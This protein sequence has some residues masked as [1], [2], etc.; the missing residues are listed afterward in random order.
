MAFRSIQFGALALATAVLTLLGQPAAMM[1]AASAIPIGLVADLSGS[2]SVYG[3]SIRNGAHLAADLLNKAGGINGDRINLLVGDGATSKTQVINLY[4]QDI[5]SAHVLALIGPTL[6][7]EAFSA[8]PIAQAAGVPVIATSNTAS[9]ITAMGS[10]IFRVSL[11]EAD[12]VPLTIKVALKHV[13]FK[14]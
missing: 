7:S 8:D 13:H 6:S 3:V 9:G 4:Q 2:A 14:I 5:N 12:V 1:H 10:Y 11:G